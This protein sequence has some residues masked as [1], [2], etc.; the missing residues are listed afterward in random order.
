MNPVHDVLVVGAGPAGTALAIRLAQAGLQVGLVEREPEAALRPGECLSPEALPALAALGH[1]DLLD[2]S[3]VARRCCGVQSIWLTS[4]PVFRDYFCERAAHGAFL[5]RRVFDARLRERAAALGITRED[6]VRV[7]HAD[8]ADDS[9]TLGGRRGE[10]PW[11]GQARFVVDATGKA[12]CI[13]RLGGARRQRLSRQVAV[14]ARL[15][16]GGSELADTE[17]L[18]I[19][20]DAQGWWS[21]ATTASGQRHLVRFFPGGD[22]Q[23][24]APQLAEQLQ[25]T[26]LMQRYAGADEQAVTAAMQAAQVSELSERLLQ[27]LSGGQRQRVWIA[28]VLAQQTPVL[29]LDEPTTYLDIAHQIELLEL[30]A[31]LNRQGR[32]IVAVLHDLNQACRYA[33]HLIAMKAGAIVAQGDPARIF[34][35]ALVQ[36]VFGVASMIIADPVSGTPLLVPLSRERAVVSGAL[37]RQAAG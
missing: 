31:E 17:W 15:P 27:E 1:A 14:A 32:T 16:R 6:D 11:R 21:G 37:P 5:E 23:R 20:A 3:T 26:R 35:E 2:D 7:T 10:H 12:S 4:E 19:E 25:R 29:L 36:E 22:G 13:A 18:L 30:L 9:I 8:F 28:M 33:S 24:T 34:T